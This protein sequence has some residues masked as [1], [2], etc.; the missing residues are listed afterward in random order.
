[1]GGE[2]DFFQKVVRAVGTGRSV[3][4]LVASSQTIT[5]VKNSLF[6]GDPEK[7]K[8]RLRAWVKDFGV[9][10][11]DLKNLSVAALLTKLLASSK[12]GGTSAML[13][14][15]RAFARE[16]GLAEIPADSA[17]KTGK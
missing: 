17:L 12:D 15:A 13:E 3:D 11:E 14:S 9:S 2:N 5:D 16:A 7:F 1:V 10:S 6:G 4:R 8:T